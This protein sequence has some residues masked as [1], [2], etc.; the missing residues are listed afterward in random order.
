MLAAYITEH[1]G[2]E[3]IQ[4]GDLPAPT[5]AVLELAG[6]APTF[7]VAYLPA[8][9]V[10]Q[11]AGPAPAVGG[12]VNLIVQPAPAVLILGGSAPRQLSY[13]NASLTSTRVSVRPILAGQLRSYRG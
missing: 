12:G 5:P 1:G 10:L 2:P 7:G 3:V 6:P 8:P 11:L 4:V 9:A 13:A